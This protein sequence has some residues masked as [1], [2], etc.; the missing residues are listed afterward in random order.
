MA[1]QYVPAGTA[2][3]A[4]T[5]QDEELVVTDRSRGLPSPPEV[6]ELLGADFARA[7]FEVDSVTVD[8]ATKPPRIRVVADGDR[9]L[10]LETIAELSRSASERL[11]GLPGIL[12][13]Y[14][15]EVSSPGVERPLTTEKHFRR[16]RGRKVELD[17][18]DGTTLTGR[19][20][21]VDSRA[22]RVVTKAR[23]DWAARE[24]ALVEIVKGVVQVEF[25][26]PAAR[27]LELLSRAE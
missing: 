11:D 21:D 2:V 17:L 26:Q 16:A 23:S 6:V 20:G 1:G 8:T 22:V 27:E 19:I 12:D 25:S 14:V 10:D 18:A 5:I 15:L 3:A 13:S 4:V 7:G 9:A 24:V